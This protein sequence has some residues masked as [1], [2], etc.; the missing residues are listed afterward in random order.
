MTTRLLRYGIYISV[1]TLIFAN[2]PA[3]ADETEL[4]RRLEEQQQIIHSQSQRIDKLEQALETILE[5]KQN[6]APNT[7]ATSR[8]VES[9]PSTS[10]KLKSPAAATSTPAKTADSSS[11]AE[12][13]FAGKR[14]AKKGY[15]PEKS[16][17]GPLPRFKS[18][19]GYSFGLSGI[20]TYD[21]AGYSQNGEDDSATVTDYRDGSR[22]KNAIMG[23]VGVFPKDWIWGMAY[24]FSDTDEGVIEG[25]RSAFALYRGFEPWWVII[26]QQNT[27]IGLDASNFSSQR[28]FMEEAM[29]AGTFGFAPGAPIMGVST[30]YRQ[31][32]KY[33]RLGLMSDP[34]KTPN[35]ADGGAVGD[36]AYG[37]HGRYAWAPIAERTRALH[38]GT[39]GYW[40]APD[41]TGFSSDPEI[42]VDSTALIDT[43]QITR[44]D[45]YYFAGLEG[46]I[47][48]G[49]FSVQTE[50]GMVNISRKNNQSSQPAFQDLMFNGY[51]LQTSYFLTGESR[52][53]YPRFAAF[54]R[55]TPKQDFSLSNGTWGAW[56]IGFRYS[57][58]DLDDGASNLSGGGVRG[59][60]ASNYTLGLNWYLNP[61]VRAQLNY[62][63]ADAENLTDAGPA[64]GDIVHIVGTRLQIEW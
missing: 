14:A 49:P 62:V 21:A 44:V 57:F 30:L 42:T 11:A 1:Y 28:V 17:F 16:F 18:P 54:W 45:D 61:F 34:A 19:S 56:E 25:L 33:I 59:G 3:E 50:Y 48:R 58:L 24:D 63:Y 15:D 9:Q 37:I 13:P 60:V 35:S 10:P 29:V 23:I 27:G 4:I 64:E 6:D 8:T 40:R 20:I 31:N 12:D 53:Y 38:V 41:A 22:V 55:V 26:G 46:A 2:V 51:Y 36:E 47:V 32:N 5:T 52:N 39:S 43:G 7:D